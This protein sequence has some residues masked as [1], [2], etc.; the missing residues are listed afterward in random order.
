MWAGMRLSHGQSSASTPGESIVPLRAASLRAAASSRTGDRSWEESQTKTILKTCGSLPR[1]S[2]ERPIWS[3]PSAQAPLLRR[4]QMSMM[5]QGRSLTIM[6]ARWQSTRRFLHVRRSVTH[7]TL[8]TYITTMT[9]GAAQQV[10]LPAG[11]EAERITSG[12]LKAQPRRCPQYC[13]LGSCM[14]RVCAAACG[15]RG[16]GCGCR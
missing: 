3:M 14:R 5:L 9:Q 1:S 16:E 4:R 11:G 2:R 13:S 12:M 10:L 7:L 8:E 6:D 15:H